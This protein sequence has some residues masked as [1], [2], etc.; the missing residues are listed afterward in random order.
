M[1]ERNN[2]RI[3]GNRGATHLVNLSDE[4][5]LLRWELCAGELSKLLTDFESHVLPS[6]LKADDFLYIKRHHEDNTSF[7]NRFNKDV[8]LPIFCFTIN[9][10]SMNS[11]SAINN[12]T[13][14]FNDE[15]SENIRLIPEIGEEQF[16]TFWTG[17]LILA[18]EPINKEIK[19]NKIVLPGSNLS[20]KIVKKD[21][22]ITPSMI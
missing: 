15:V 1:H 3:K 7:R 18:K 6:T 22:V 8:E 9:P 20:H 13:I 5:P 11:F 16:L 4:F 19:E 14:H 12:T 2:T 10:F 17:R 21:Q